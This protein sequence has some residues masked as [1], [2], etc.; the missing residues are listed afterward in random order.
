MPT[1]VK[2]LKKG[3]RLVVISFH[4]LEDRIVKRFIKKHATA[5]KFDKRMP[6]APVD[7]AILKI[8]GKPVKAS[9]IELVNNPRARSAIMR[10][11][12]KL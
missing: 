8:I 3:G 7:T 11:A 9:D 10:V 6:I 2:S 5:G 1:A 12:E 4:S